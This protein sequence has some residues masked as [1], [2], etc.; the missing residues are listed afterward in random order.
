M[1]SEWG[2]FMNVWKTQLIEYISALDDAESPESAEELIISELERLK[3]EFIKNQ[4]VIKSTMVDNSEQLDK[5][6]G[7]SELITLYRDLFYGRQDVFAVRWDNDKTGAH[8][9]APKCKNE[10]DR[11]MCGKAMK[12]KGA[13]KK[14]AYRENQEITNDLIQRHFVGTGRD[15]F[16]MG[17]YPLLEDETCRFLAIDFDK[18]NWK[19]ELLAAKAIYAEYGVQSYIERS[20]SGNGGHLWI[21]FNEPIEAYIVRK[22]GIKVLET[23]MNRTGNSKFDSFDR[24][25]PNQDHMPKGGYGNLIASPLQRQAVEKGNSVFVDDTFTMYSSQT[26]VLQSIKRYSRTEILNI[27]KLFPDIIL[28]DISDREIEEEDKTLPWEKKKEEK[29]PEDLPKT[30]EIVLYD[31]IYVYKNN[32]HSFLKKKFIGLTV[33]HNPEY[34]LARNLRKSV[35]DIPMWIQCFD[36]DADYLMLPVGLESTLV[37]ICESYNVSVKIID[38]RFAG[39]AIDV[40]FYGDLREKQMKAVEE[41]LAASNGILHANTAFGKT[42]AAIAMIAERRVNTLIIVDR[43]SLLDQW[44]ERLSVF[45][46]I[47]KKEIGVIGGGKKKPTG[48]IDVAISQS[49]YRDNTVSDFVK[50]YGQIICDECHHASAVGLE[51]IMKN[52]PAKYKYG[53]TATLKRKDGKERIVLMQL[54]PVRYKDLSK[55]TSELEHKVMVQETGIS[56]DG[57]EKEHTTNELYDYLYIN[58]IR[59]MQIVMDV[60]NCLDEKRYPII[61]TE[62]K[63]HI[64]LLEKE[65][66]SYVK[67][68]KLHGGLKKKEREGIMEELQNLPEDEARVIIA[69]SKYVGEGF[70]YPILDTLFLT[71]PISW[72]GRVKQYAGR[73][74]RD[75]HEKKEVRI[76]DYLDSDID[77][78]VKMYGKRCKGY[79]S[80]GYE[81]IKK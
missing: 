18:G 68:Y 37:E 66:S 54:G 23:A 44:C 76:Y 41:L 72:S 51:Q 60:K 47:P 1:K 15:S 80:M 10:W 17:I 62:R 14:C 24:L 64:D 19:K 3:R 61:L 11:K 16:V 63:E 53:L 20:R 57:L 5:S 33:F 71:L 75:Y 50:G 32:L 40:S 12:I 22:L 58:P 81:I 74:H 46:N 70:D 38:K 69:T 31:K 48:R 39:N 30:I 56:I 9:Y 29:I 25:F 34:Y 27:L 73:L 35:Q 79:R 28:Q 8:G 4:E 2:T 7:M 45:L 43:V 21:F 26:A 6:M 77:T 49:L 78:A 36:E 42:V 67:V 59:N 65:L 55:V 13:C 52:S